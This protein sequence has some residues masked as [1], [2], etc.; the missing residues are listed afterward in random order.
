MDKAT[1]VTILQMERRIVD[2]G[3][4]W[5]PFK[6]NLDTMPSCI[7]Q[8]HR[9]T[10]MK[11]IFNGLLTS[12][13]LRFMHDVVLRACVFCGESESDDRRRWVHCHVLQAI[14]D[15]LYADSTTMTMSNDVFHM[16]VPLD[17]RSQQFFLVF[18]HATWRCRCVIVRGFTFFEQP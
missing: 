18:L 2:S 16:Q 17:G 4:E 1:E 3:L 12:A 15:E 14:F 7:P 6:A 5:V 13:R 8:G 9:I 11:Y 10:F